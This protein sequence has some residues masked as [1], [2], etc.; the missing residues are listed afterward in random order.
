MKN[1]PFRRK[2]KHFIKN[3]QRCSAL[4]IEN[5]DKLEDLFLNMGVYYKNVCAHTLLNS[6]KKKSDRFYRLCKRMGSAARKKGMFVD[7]MSLW[8]IVDWGFMYDS[9]DSSVKITDPREMKFMKFF[10]IDVVRTHSV[11]VLGESEQ[12]VM[13]KKKDFGGNVYFHAWD[14]QTP[15]AVNFK[16]K[17]I[18]ETL[19]QNKGSEK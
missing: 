14:K 9:V 8:Q 1:V 7:G 12:D 6:G 3:A 13:K 2:L 5:P 10:K 18:T 17:D 16:V 19:F 11:F 15:V 4:N